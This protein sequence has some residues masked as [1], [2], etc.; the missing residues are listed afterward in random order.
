MKKIT[1]TLERH[2]TCSYVIHI[3]YNILDR[4]CLLITS[5]APA[6]HYVIICD[7][8]ISHLYG[9]KL[10]DILRKMNQRVDVITFPAGESS[11]NIDTALVLISKMI[12]LGVD[13]SSALIALGGGVTGDMVSFIASIYMRSVPYVHV[14]T[15]LMAQV[16]SSIGGKTGI[17]LSFGKNLLGTFYQ[18]RGTFID[19]Q[20]LDTLPESELI[21]GLAEVVKYGIIDD[22]KLFGILEKNIED[23]QKK[24]KKLMEAI[25][26]KS[27]GIKKRIVEIDETDIGIRRILNFG[28]T[29][30]HAIE[31]ASSYSISHGNAISAGMI[32]SARISE[33]LRHLPSI[34]RERIETLIRALGL[35]GY[36]PDSL[37]SAGI[38]SRLKNDKKKE[39]DS[40][41]FVLLKK[42]GVPFING[43][44]DEDII[45]ETIEEL[46]P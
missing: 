44:V 10:A 29:I 6:H 13:R 3:G 28:H 41:N 31:A 43:T 5:A 46:R 35:S 24:K 39:G 38:L 36:I 34:D 26:V 4:I 15:T 45:K 25:V 42:L 23:I 21:N 37:D 11:K 17:D 22:I 40:T 16:D 18:P 8:N 1:L 20:L 33:K 27:C 12:D 14:P 7:S 2:S 30:G 19:L 32:A 9:E